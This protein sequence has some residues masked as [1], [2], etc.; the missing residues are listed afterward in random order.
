MLRA[1][2]RRLFPFVTDSVDPVKVK[3]T[4]SLLWALNALLLMLV[5]DGKYNS[6]SLR[7]RT[8]TKQVVLGFP[9]K[10]AWH[11]LGTNYYSQ[12]KALL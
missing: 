3:F 1:N 7:I 9:S 4:N 10:N 2:N 8:H 6:Y 11:A 5:A 12:P